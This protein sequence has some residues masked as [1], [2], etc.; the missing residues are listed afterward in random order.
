MDDRYKGDTWR[1]F[2]LSLKAGFTYGL[3][4]EIM[5]IGTGYMLYREYRTN[6]SMYIVLEINRKSSLNVLFQAFHLLKIL[7]LV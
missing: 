7:I 1:K 2:K 4:L 5:F 6:S 3:A